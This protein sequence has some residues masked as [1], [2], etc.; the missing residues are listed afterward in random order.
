M[1]DGGAWHA[2]VHVVE[3]F[4]GIEFMTNNDGLK[5]HAFSHLRFSLIE[6]PRFKTK[7]VSVTQTVIEIKRESKVQ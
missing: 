6:L 1:K 2:A 4:E 7:E 3:E 5:A